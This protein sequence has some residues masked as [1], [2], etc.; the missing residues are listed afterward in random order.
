MAKF[1]FVSPLSYLYPSANFAPSAL[2]VI[3][4]AVPCLVWGQQGSAVNVA[5]SIPVSEFYSID[6]AGRT[7]G[8]SL[9]LNKIHIFHALSGL[10]SAGV[11]GA[12]ASASVSIVENLLSAGQS[13]SAAGLSA[14]W[15]IGCQL[16]NAQTSAS[17][18]QASEV[19]GTGWGFPGSNPSAFAQVGL[20]PSALSQ[21]I[22][23][24][25]FTAPLVFLGAPGET[26]TLSAAHTATYVPRLFPIAT[27]LN[28]SA[29]L[30]VSA[31]WI[32]YGTMLEFL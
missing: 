6:A 22:Q 8:G 10:T 3:A 21:L 5:L 12:L 32:H 18:V 13:I 24:D 15:G 27:Y 29:R 9:V 7:G 1:Q 26:G 23:Q 16:P 11:G 2:G 14:T 20:V 28:V 4:S 25:T 31:T 19:S 17:H 30:G